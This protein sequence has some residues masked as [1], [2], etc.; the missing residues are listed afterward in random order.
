MRKAANYALRSVVAVSGL[1]I[2]LRMLI[3]PFERPFRVA[4]PLNS[5]GWCGLALTILLVTNDGYGV[6]DALQKR[7]SGLRN[8]LAVLGLTALTT[9]VYWRT[10][11]FYFLSDDFVLV[12]L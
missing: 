3:G 2:A 4:I 11:D 5:E 1:V 6:R 12:K 9:A 10:L 8:V 7:I